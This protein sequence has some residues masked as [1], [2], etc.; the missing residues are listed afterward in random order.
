MKR[1][2][3]SKN[4]TFAPKKQQLEVTYEHDPKIQEEKRRLEQ[5]YRNVKWTEEQ[6][7]TINAIDNGDNVF[8][9]APGG[10]GKSFLLRYLIH[11]ARNELG[12]KVAVTASTGIA[13]V[14]LGGTTIHSALGVGMAKQTADELVSLK[15]KD[16]KFVEEWL[17]YDLLIIDEISMVEP[18][19]LDK[20]DKILRKVR[21][22]PHKPFGGI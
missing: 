12:L 18:E 17:G 15:A 9:T 13:A 20:I 14:P 3:F 6:Q 16:K 19:F 22:Q 10:A 11:R 5:M 21:A 1:K 2:F 7:N 8:L 4:K